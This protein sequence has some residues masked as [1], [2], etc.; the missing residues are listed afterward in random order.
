MAISDYNLL[1][2]SIVVRQPKTAVDVPQTV[3][4]KLRPDAKGITLAALDAHCKNYITAH[5]LS[6][7]RKQKF[8]L[9]LLPR[10][11]TMFD[12]LLCASDYFSTLINDETSYIGGR[13]NV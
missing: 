4:S 6:D 2:T 5:N 9:S 3:G 13:T 11:H 12:S 7:Y 10:I 8:E 1:Y